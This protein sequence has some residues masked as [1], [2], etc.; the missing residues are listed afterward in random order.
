MSNKIDTRF[1]MC[2]HLVTCNCYSQEKI[3][4]EQNTPV[5]NR[6]KRAET[7]KHPSHED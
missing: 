2:R 6:L 1:L 3:A 7:N 5:T 4:S